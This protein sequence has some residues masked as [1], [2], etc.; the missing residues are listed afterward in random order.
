MSEVR[1]F[2]VDTPRG[3]SELST[4]VH[5]RGGTWL[6]SNA[7]FQGPKRRGHAPGAARAR[8]RAPAAG[9]Q[10]RAGGG[11]GASS[12]SRPRR[13]RGAVVAP[14][15]RAA[16]CTRCPGDAAFDA[17]RSA[18]R[19]WERGPPAPDTH[20]TRRDSRGA[21][22]P[23]PT[24]PG[25]GGA[26]PPQRARA[27]CGRDGPLGPGLAR[28]PA[29]RPPV[30]AAVAPPRPPRRPLRAVRPRCSGCGVGSE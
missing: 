1:E 28:R 20:R 29:R 8:R 25:R 19:A 22:H 12:R 27:R 4:R 10:R 7:P 3:C 15:P 17:A 23:R 5:I 24:H 2:A 14:R 18:E 13:V 9:P 16:A 21:P 6:R 26:H 30:A 11:A